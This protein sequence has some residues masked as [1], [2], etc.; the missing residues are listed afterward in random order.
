MYRNLSLLLF[1]LIVLV[2][3]NMP[4]AQIKVSVAGG[5]RLTA[6]MPHGNIQGEQETEVQIVMATFLTD[7]AQKH[8]R[9][10]FAADVK[11]ATP[12]KS[13]RVEE[14]SGSKA[15]VL[16][17]DKDPKL[18]GKMNLWHGDSEN[19]T[20]DNPRLFWLHD[21]DETFLVY[22]FIFTFADGKVV[23]LHHVAY[24]IPMVKAHVRKELGQTE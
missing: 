21:I 11:I 5:E 16:I 12:L 8:G 14:V 1:P 9:Y 2:G 18:M 17:D 7:P 6:N 15:D 24:F 20:Y 23:R 4:M 10:V 13:V 22:R 19:M 3:C